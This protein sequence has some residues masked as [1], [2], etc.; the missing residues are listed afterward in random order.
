M[1]VKN[2]CE[3]TQP[4]QTKK[5]HTKQHTQRGEKTRTTRSMTDVSAVMKNSSESCWCGV[6]SDVCVGLC[7]L[8]GP[9]AG[10]GGYCGCEL[11]SIVLC[12]SS[13]AVGGKSKR[14]THS[15]HKKQRTGQFGPRARGTHLHLVVQTRYDAPTV[16]THDNDNDNNK[17][18]AAPNE[19][20]EGIKKKEEGGRKRT[21]VKARISSAI[22]WSGLSM[23]LL[24]SSV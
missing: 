14:A 9:S 12:A 16:A 10:F 19:K 2:H 4:K 3:A 15:E 1:V 17:R 24:A 22:R 7:G 5:T 21:L 8:S 18:C 23:S 20:K 6:D 11:S 13:V